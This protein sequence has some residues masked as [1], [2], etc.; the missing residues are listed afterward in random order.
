MGVKSTCLFHWLHCQVER[1]ANF[2][3]GPLRE[4]SAGTVVKLLMGSLQM[5]P[6]SRGKGF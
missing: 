3:V 4:G 1:V 6:S 5:V 2:L